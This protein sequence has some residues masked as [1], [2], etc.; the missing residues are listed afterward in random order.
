MDENFQFN[1]MLKR[2]SQSV[3]LLGNTAVYCLLTG[4][5]LREGEVCE[6]TTVPLSGAS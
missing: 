6:L 2:R 5:W 4:T 1:S 3:I